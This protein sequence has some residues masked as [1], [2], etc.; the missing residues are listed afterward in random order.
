MDEA[1]LSNPESNDKLDDWIS[2]SPEK[3]MTVLNPELRT[4]VTVIKGF[5]II[6][7]DETRKD[8]HPKAIESILDAIKRIEILLDAMADFNRIQRSGT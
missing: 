1:N 6:L 8:M 3:F 4:P 7:A 5:V 2:W